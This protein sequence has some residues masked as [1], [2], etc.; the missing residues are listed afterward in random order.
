[1]GRFWTRTTQHAAAR[2]AKIY[3][4]KDH[5]THQKA[6]RHQGRQTKQHKKQLVQ[7]CHKPWQAPHHRWEPH[8]SGF[9]CSACGVRIHQALTVSIIEE[10]LAQTCPRLRLE[11]EYPDHHSPHKP[12]PKKLTRAQVITKLLAQQ[13]DTIPAEDTH[14][15]EETKGYL[16]C[17]K[18]GIS[19][20]KR[21]K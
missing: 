16:R 17:G 9:H 3:A 19:V 8:R 2:L 4:A 21:T 15:L 5:Y 11:E 18:C 13:Q 6:P 10:R 12:L 14:A 20:H 7:Q 1:M